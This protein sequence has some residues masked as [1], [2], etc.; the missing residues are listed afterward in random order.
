MVSCLVLL[1]YSIFG[2]SLTCLCVCVYCLIYML[3]LIMKDQREL[4]KLGEYYLG[5][6]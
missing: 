1:S 6:E 2:I 4:I 3:L 5:C